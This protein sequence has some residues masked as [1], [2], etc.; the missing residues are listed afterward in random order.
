MKKKGVPLIENAELSLKF[1]FA[2]TMVR[3]GLFDSVSDDPIPYQE[4]A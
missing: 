3:A 2:V 4:T 1:R